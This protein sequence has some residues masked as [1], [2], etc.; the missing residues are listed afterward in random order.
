MFNFFWHVCDYSLIIIWFLVMLRW[1]V[2]FYVTFVYYF[3]FLLDQMSYMSTY[4]VA[5]DNSS[6]SVH[7]SSIQKTLSAVL[8]QQS[9]FNVLFNRKCKFGNWMEKVLI[10]VPFFCACVSLIASF[11]SLTLGIILCMLSVNV[12]CFKNLETDAASVD[13]LKQKRSLVSYSAFC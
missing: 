11:L 10:M 9:A 7:I 13:Y 2:V 1:Q 4:I 12:M 3:P 5:L 8:F 6:S